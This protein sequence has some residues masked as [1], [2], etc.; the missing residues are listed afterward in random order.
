M[1]AAGS[2]ACTG[3]S[4]W[5]VVGAGWV[6]G[7]W[8]WVSAA[9]GVGSPLTT[10]TV[11]M[12]ASTHRHVRAMVRVTSSGD[13][14]S[15][16]LCFGMGA[17]LV[18]VEVPPTLLLYKGYAD[19]CHAYANNGSHTTKKVTADGHTNTSQRIYAHARQHTPTP[20]M[21]CATRPR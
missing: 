6:V 4:V 15:G 1:V 20:R 14:V 17:A 12:A 11:A 18:G 7:S 8:A 16:L 5:G 10:P 9:A 13:R 21:G 2:A 19:Y 3:V